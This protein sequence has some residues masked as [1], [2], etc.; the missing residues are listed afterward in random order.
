MKITI[1]GAGNI[2]GT[3]GGKWAAA[4]HEVV[5]GLRESRGPR[6]QAF[7]KG[8]GGRVRAVSVA[9]AVQAGEIVLFAIP[10]AAVEETAAA[11]AAGLNGKLIIDATN[12]FTAG[13]INSLDVIAA[14]APG[15]RLYRV[16]NSLGWEVFA[17]PQIGGVKA[18]HFFAGADGPDRAIVEQL[19]LEIGLRPVWA[20]GLDQVG[21]VDGVGKLWVALAYGRGLDR[22]LGFK[23]LQD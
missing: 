16:F 21:A 8:L 6:T 10:A 18:D 20:G 14:A 2:G 5:F 23:L 9:E 15:A 7:L 11:N 17:N 19:I 22:H 12:K 4:G 1:L 13:V 3:L